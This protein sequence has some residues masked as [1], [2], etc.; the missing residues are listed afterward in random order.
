MSKKRKSTAS[1]SSGATSS[2]YFTDDIAGDRGRKT[3]LKTQSRHFVENTVSAVEQ[4]AQQYIRRLSKKERS[5]SRDSR[6]RTRKH[7]LSE[8]GEKSGANATTISSSAASELSRVK[9]ELE[10]IKKELDPLKK[11][12][13]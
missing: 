10:A 11:V 5:K 6:E 12:S 13:R 3:K 8:A 7:P 1:S 2:V 4:Q 9:K